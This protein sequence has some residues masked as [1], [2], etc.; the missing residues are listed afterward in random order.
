MKKDSAIIISE[1]SR[2]ECAPA[3]YDY[4]VRHYFEWKEQTHASTRLERPSAE[5]VGSRDIVAI[6]CDPN[7]NQFFSLELFAQ[8]APHLPFAASHSLAL[9]IYSNKS[10]N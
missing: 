2:I 9:V 5:A 8:N 3:N 7:E 1:N 10:L 6:M 4:L